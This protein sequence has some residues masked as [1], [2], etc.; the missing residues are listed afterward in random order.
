MAQREKPS[1]LKKGRTTQEAVP[2]AMKPIERT[3]EGQRSVAS[4]SPNYCDTVV[5]IPGRTYEKAC[6]IRR[7]MIARAEFD[8]G[9]G[10]APRIAL[11]RVFAKAIDEYDRNHP[12]VG[13]P[14]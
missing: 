3:C 7:R 14:A 6:A 4:P 8:G 5:R 9:G 12:P 13:D 11:G 1:W 10:L 2:P